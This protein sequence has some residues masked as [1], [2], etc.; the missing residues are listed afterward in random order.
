M[1]IKESITWVI[2]GISCILGVWLTG[3]FESDGDS[4]GTT[5][6]ELLSSILGLILFLA[7]II[8]MVLLVRRQRGP[9]T[10][11]DIANWEA[12][13]SKG[14]RRYIRTGF[15]KGTLFGLTAISVP[16]ISAIALRLPVK[17]LWVLGVIVVSGTLAGYY[18]AIKK[19]ESNKKDY[20]AFMRS[21]QGPR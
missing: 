20:E 4:H 18:G 19:W 9:F 11:S 21:K 7:A 15:V 6:L 17:S 3:F 14:K 5:G 13:K 1:P 12:L 16:L 8:G 10:D 2:L